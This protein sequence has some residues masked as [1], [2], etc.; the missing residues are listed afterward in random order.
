[1]K[2]AVGTLFYYYLFISYL[3][4][5]FGTITIWYYY[6]IGMYSIYKL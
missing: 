3:E 2:R 6:F 1:M 5:L 4:Q